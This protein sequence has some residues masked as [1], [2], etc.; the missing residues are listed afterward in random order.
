MYFFLSSS[1]EMCASAILAS[2]ANVAT[3]ATTKG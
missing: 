2:T 3:A 1:A